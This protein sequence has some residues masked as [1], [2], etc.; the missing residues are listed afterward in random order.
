[1]PQS[2][3]CV[4]IHLVFSTKNR[5]P[6]LR[7]ESLRGEMLA[8]LG[9]ASKTLGCPPL[10]VGGTEDHIHM[11]CRLGRTITQSDWVKEIKRVSSAWIKERDPKTKDFAW[12]AGY[13]SF[14][15]SSSNLEQVRE[16]ISR[17]GE[18]HRR[19]SFQDEYREFLRK[20]GMEW[21]EQH[22]WE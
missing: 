5:I 8:Y 18:H 15:V 19:Q 22:V 13:G 1:M 16:Y 11:L 7:N 21:D 12:Q 10:I 6:F 4:H 17:Q 20:H 3:S 9:G 2:L 14:S